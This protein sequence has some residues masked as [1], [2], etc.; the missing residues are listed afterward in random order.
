M[1][2]ILIVLICSFITKFTFSL[3]ESIKT[4]KIKSKGNDVISYEEFPFPYLYNVFATFGIILIFSVF[5]F[6]LLSILLNKVLNFNFLLIFLLGLPIISF[7]TGLIILIYTSIFIDKRKGIPCLYKE[8]DKPYFYF[9][10]ISNC[11]MAA[12]GIFALIFLFKF[13]IIKF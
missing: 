1:I 6:Y 5:L 7:L 8:K 12:C 13:G 3:I 11:I 4:K 9:T 10:V 2:L